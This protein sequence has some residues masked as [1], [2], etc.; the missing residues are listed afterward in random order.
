MAI[1]QAAS[2]TMAPTKPNSSATMVKMKSVCCSGMYSSSFWAPSM[3]PLPASPPEPM[4]IMALQQLIA[5]AQRVRRFGSHHR[6]DPFPLVIVQAEE[7][8]HRRHD[9]DQQGDDGRR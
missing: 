1:A 5:S 6:V 3:K 7:V 9:R 8:D 2:I 4:A